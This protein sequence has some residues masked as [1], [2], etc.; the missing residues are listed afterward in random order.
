MSLR[1]LF[2]NIFTV[3]KKRN[4]SLM[5][6]SFVLKFFHCSFFIWAIHFFHFTVPMHY[7]S[8]APVHRVVTTN[9]KLYDQLVVAQM[10]GNIV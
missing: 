3:N 4:Y 2:G 6:F 8:V 5:K 1:M 9:K 10:A 7:A